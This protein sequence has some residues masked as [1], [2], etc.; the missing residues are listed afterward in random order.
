MPYLKTKSKENGSRI[1]LYYEDYGKGKPIV[2][3]H[4]WPLSHRMWDKQIESLVE[5][6]YRVIAYDRRG[7]GQSSKP[8]SGYDYNTLAKDLK[9]IISE[10]K[11]KQVTL[12]GFSMGGGEVARYI[13]KYGTELIKKAVLVGAVTPYLLETEDNDNGVSGEV[14]ER[15]GCFF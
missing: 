15:Q 14:F 5:A 6:E 4:G 7:F 8:Y 11:L 13:G 9:D 3:I 12:V 1:K 2:L 10:L